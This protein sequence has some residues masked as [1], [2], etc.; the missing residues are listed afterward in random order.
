M[1]RSGTSKN[2]R[3]IDTL[4]FLFALIVLIAAQ[5]IYI[6]NPPMYMGTIETTK[7]QED[8]WKKFGAY[9]KLDEHV[10]LF[11]RNHL[12]DESISR[13]ISHV[14]IKIISPEGVKYGT[15][16]LPRYFDTVTAFNA[17]MTTAD[18][19]KAPLNLKLL[20]R[21]YVEKGKIVFPQVT[22]GCELDLSVEFTSH[23]FY[24]NYEH[25]FA[26]EIP[27]RMGSFS[28]KADN[29]CSYATKLYGDVNLGNI[30]ETNGPQR[31][32][33]TWQM[34]NL[35]AL[36]VQ[37]YSDWQDSYQPRVAVAMRNS[38]IRFQDDETFGTW[39]A[40]STNFKRFY[41]NERDRM[42]GSR[43]FKITDQIV[44]N[45][46]DTFERA[47]KIAQWIHTNV[48]LID[49][50]FK[51]AD[52]NGIIRDG[53]GNGWEITCVCNAMLHRAG[54]SSTI[55][56][57]RPHSQGGFDSSFV[58]R[59]QCY[60]PLIVATINNRNHAIFPFFTY[61]AVGE[62]PVD[63]FDLCGLNLGTGKIIR[64]PPSVSGIWEERDSSLLDF[65]QKDPL[66]Y[67]DIQ[68]SG[69]AAYSV[70]EQLIDKNDI[71]KKNYFQVQ[72]KKNG[73]RNELVSYSIEHLEDVGAALKVRLTVAWPAI[74]A[75]K[76]AGMYYSLTELFDEHFTGLDSTR[77]K[78]FFLPNDI[79][80]KETVVV[81]AHPG[82]SFVP[83]FCCEQLQSSLM[84]VR[85][86]I[87]ADKNSFEREIEINHVRFPR[88]S[89]I[90]HLPEIKKLNRIKESS[91]VLR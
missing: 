35:E 11:Q 55:V 39:K 29:E 91:I 33:K 44:N 25:W 78:P 64:I 72:L 65:T 30:K 34:E 85:C 40:L 12:T 75:R 81:K 74:S 32:Q 24:T 10:L 86:G 16:V 48:S 62:Y 50:P 7:A 36:E 57:T 82:K 73:S 53:K 76:T 37:N 2:R 26:H 66:Q 70:R 59:S 15:V 83:Q 68:Y 71:E 60:T 14:I 23:L 5:C 51:F 28:I 18:G 87:N 79:H 80:I 4:K 89:I 22:S 52:L 90:A 9:Y 77:Q 63:F 20:R 84:K 67:S 19:N 38:F 47:Q 27:V 17:T 45:V 8:K 3:R 21:N 49:K 31:G 42:S 56:E 54:I 6:K 46:A 41:S 58:S 1:Q 13:Y 43:L 88:D 69:I 61:A